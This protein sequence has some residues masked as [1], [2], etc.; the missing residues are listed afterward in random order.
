MPEYK[1]FPLSFAIAPK[2]NPKLISIQIEGEKPLWL[3]GRGN[4][5]VETSA[6]TMIFQ[7]PLI[8]Q[9]LKG[10]NKHIDGTFV[11]RSGDEVAI[12]VGRYDRLRAKNHFG[13]MA[14]EIAQGEIEYDF[15]VAPKANPK[16][17]LCRIG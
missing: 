14:V 7:K 12:N 15:V 2:A 8:F 16:L 3:D 17:I 4:L 13:W 9:N 11:I 1:R 10:Q 5:H 6:G